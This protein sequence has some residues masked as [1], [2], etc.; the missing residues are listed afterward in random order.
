M[1]DKGH[2]VASPLEPFEAA[3]AVAGPAEIRQ[4][5]DDVACKR[6]TGLVETWSGVETAL[7]NRM[8]A[9]NL[10][11]LTAMRDATERTLRAAD[12]VL[13]DRD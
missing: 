1:K 8:I 9:R 13:A 5:Q 10:G 3:S 6:R 11:P 7:Q 12:T 2:G 4:A